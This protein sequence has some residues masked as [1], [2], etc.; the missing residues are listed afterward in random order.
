[1]ARGALRLRKA[2]ILV[3]VMTAGP[4]VAFFRRSFE[5]LLDQFNDRDQ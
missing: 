4:L 2:L 3:L 5:A 1:M